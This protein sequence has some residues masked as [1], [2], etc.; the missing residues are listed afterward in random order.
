MAGDEPETFPATS[1]DVFW[2]FLIAPFWGNLS[3]TTGGLVSWEIH[4]SSM[5]PDLFD[6]VNAF[7]E[8]ESGDSQFN[9]TWMFISFWED[10]L[11]SETSSYV[12]VTTNTV[13]LL[14]L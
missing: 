1:A 7:I 3:S 12:G 2:T 8:D 14:I 10:V 13:V 6:L 9:G 4:T 11:A 5:S